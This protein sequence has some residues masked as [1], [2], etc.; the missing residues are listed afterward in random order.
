[1]AFIHRSVISSN[2][3]LVIIIMLLGPYCII[4]IIIH[5]HPTPHQ[6]WRKRLGG[7]VPSEPAGN[8]ANLSPATDPCRT[9]TLPWSVRFLAP[10]LKDSHPQSQ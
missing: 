2:F 5:P 6:Q 3:Y 4:S 1:M 7:L 9:D 10:E 8:R